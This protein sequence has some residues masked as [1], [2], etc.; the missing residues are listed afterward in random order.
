MTNTRM[1][2][3]SFLLFALS[4]LVGCNER[5]C[6]DGK[7]EVGDRCVEPDGGPD[8]ADTGPA[9]TLE[10]M[11][12]SIVDSGSDIG[13]VSDA[14]L[15]CDDCE[16]GFVCHED[17][18]VLSRCGDGIV[19]HSADEDCDDGMN[20]DEEDGCTD[21]CT[22]SC[23]SDAVCG[24]GDLCNGSERCDLATHTCSAGT[25]LDCDDGD[26]CT[27]DAC[28]E[29]GCVNS[30]IDADGDGYAASSLGRCATLPTSGGD[31]DD[32][33]ASTYPGA[34][35]QCDDIS[36]DCDPRTDEDTSDSLRCYPD[37]DRDRYPGMDGALD[38][39]V[40]PSMFVPAREDGEFDCD[41]TNSFVHPGWTGEL[42]FRMTPTPGGSFDFDCDGRE[43]KQF[44]RVSSAPFS[45]TRTSFG[46]L[47]VPS[48]NQHWVDGRVPACGESAISTGCTESCVPG[49]SEGTQACR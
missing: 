11:D 7:V 48:G 42:G 13:D 31:C 49:E 16:T 23:E 30:L 32:D 9:D 34:P 40:C 29:T 3:Y 27:S 1:T 15:G 20:G 41:D 5:I 28:D 17:M 8:E 12:S 39:C 4:V 25:A 10:T 33:D 45:C 38:A 21:T 36:H 46:C 35:E 2:R 26:N 18:C 24:D 22:F 47:M 44:I 37:M 19:D 6:P 43:T 14:D